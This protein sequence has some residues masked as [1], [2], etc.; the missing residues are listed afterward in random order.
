MRIFA[1][2]AVV[3][4][5][6]GTSTLG[7]SQ[8]YPVKPVRLVA[9][10]PAGGSVDLLARI[11]AQKMTETMGQQ[12]IVENR[13]GAASNIAVAYVV[14][15]VPDGYTLLVGSAGGLATN[16]A[17]YRNLPFNPTTDLTPIGI[18]AY[19]ANV[20]VVNPSVPAK[21]VKEFIELA[22]AKP[23]AITVGSAGTGSSQ[24]ISLE[25]FSS[26]AGVKVL[27]VPYKGGAP[28]TTDLLGGQIAAIFAPIP[29]ATPHIRSG[30]LRPL[31]VTTAKR[32]ASLPD[33][34]TIQE[35]GLPKFEFLGFM[36][37]VGPRGLPPALVTRLNREVNTVLADPGVQKRFQDSG[38]ELGGGTPAQLQAL[39]RS[40]AEA[41]AKLVKEV[42]IQPVD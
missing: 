26:M 36:G 13:P 41:M 7:W 28:A 33:I 2:G 9:G 22:R 42:G 18:M 5:A 32:S 31:G 20:L 25:S 17:L 10:F 3:L 23:G 8:N 12:V 37:L 39:I 19:Q 38:L 15:A 34:P 4:C 30:R 14:K 16:M 29:E 27:H 6:A 35:G 40:Q 11:F 1:V 21:T 24:H